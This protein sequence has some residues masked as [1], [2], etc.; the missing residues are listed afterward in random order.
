MVFTNASSATFRIALCW[1]GV[2]LARSFRNSWFFRSRWAMLNW[3]TTL[4]LTLFIHFWRKHTE[5]PRGKCL[6]STG[7]RCAFPVKDHITSTH[8]VFSSHLGTI[9]A[10]IWY[11]QGTSALLN[12]WP[13]CYR[14]EIWTKPNSDSSNSDLSVFFSAMKD[15]L[16]NKNYI[17]WTAAA[18]RN[19]I[20]LVTVFPW[21]ELPT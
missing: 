13:D 6:F 21:P 5:S 11:D 14:V 3:L 18:R 10:C 20:C 17:A 16:Q 19:F 2:H 4:R 12:R 1:A 7:S 15:V 8:M 9:P